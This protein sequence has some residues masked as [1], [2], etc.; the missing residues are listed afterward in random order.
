MSNFGKQRAD[1]HGDFRRACL[2][3][4][5]RNFWEPFSKKI[6]LGRVSNERAQVKDNETTFGYGPPTVLTGALSLVALQDRGAAGSPSAQK[7]GSRIRR[8]I[9]RSYHRG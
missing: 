3:L 4:D 6:C 9:V 7:W 2:A 5:L 8:P 1:A